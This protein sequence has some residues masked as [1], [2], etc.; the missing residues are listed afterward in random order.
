MKDIYYIF[1]FD[2]TH[3]AISADK[4]LEAN[5]VSHKLIPVP[6]KISA[7]CGFCLRVPKDDAEKAERLFEEK[8]VEFAGVYAAE[9]EG[10]HYERR[11]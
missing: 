11:D 4:L 7:G 10:L 3:W 8:G 1:T 9:K 6:Q 2:T 5:A